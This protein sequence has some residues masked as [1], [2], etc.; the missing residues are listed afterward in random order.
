MI[1]SFPSTLCLF[2]YRHAW[3][4]STITSSREPLASDSAPEWE[5]EPVP[6]WSVTTWPSFTCYLKS[7][8]PWWEKPH[9]ASA[10][11]TGHGWCCHLLHSDQL[12]NS[13]MSESPDPLHFDSHPPGFLLLAD[14][15]WTKTFPAQ[16]SPPTSFSSDCDLSIL[17]PCD[18]WHP[19]PFLPSKNYCLDSAYGFLGATLLLHSVLQPP[20]GRIL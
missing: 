7:L 3:D 2:S 14:P 9:P 6:P 19:G 1:M 20:G 4:C 13:S 15:F 16:A 11:A 17:F 5:W 12:S 10:A 18:Y 8:G